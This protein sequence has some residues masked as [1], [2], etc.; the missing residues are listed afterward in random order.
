MKSQASEGDISF[1]VPE[2]FNRVRA[3]KVLH[4][5]CSDLSRNQVQ[6]LF[7]E[8]LVWHDNE[9]I[10]KSR[11]LSTGDIIYYSIPPLKKLILE[12][13]QIPLEILYEDEFIAVVN[14]AAGIV[15][16]P[17][18]GTV[19]PTLVHALLYHCRDSLSGIGGVERP[20]IV[21]R[22]DKNTSG[23]IIIA[24]TDAAYIELSRMFEKRD[25]KKIYLAVVSGV[26]SLLSGTIKEPIGRHHG[27]RIKM[28]VNHR[29]RYAHTD[30]QREE[31][32]G[33]RAALL[34]IRIHTGR[35]HQIRVHL[36]HI[37]HP[38]VGDTLYGY[39][40]EDSASP[41]IPRVL[42]HAS[43]LTFNHPITR[44]ALK[45]EASIPDDFLAVLN[46]FR[47]ALSS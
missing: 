12:P 18:N 28:S 17:G 31:I 14:K 9:A 46:D 26:P 44:Q 41:F 43:E 30:W 19:D 21:H 38:I 25:L 27:N 35:T 24:K 39:K 5:Q 1:E 20:G 11:R 2:A 13:V 45:I 29:G 3:D 36:S 47:E 40:P 32:F 42:L 16:H 8:G 6:R 15:V 4:D 7:D 23:A 37:R 34:K 33:D 22:L 10:I